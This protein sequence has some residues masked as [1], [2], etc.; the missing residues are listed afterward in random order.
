MKI[1]DY[2][3]F[4]PVIKKTAITLSFVTILRCSV[5]PIELEESF[6]QNSTNP[7]NFTCTDSN[8]E[9]RLINNGTISYRLRIFSPD[10]TNIIQIINIDPGTTTN[11]I[12]FPA[13]DIL[14]AIDNNSAGVTDIKTEV[15]MQNCEIFELVILQDNT[16][17]PSTPTSI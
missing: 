3:N 11:W 6:M 12:S 15:T 2:E 4:Y 14:F 16:M 8:P 1:L 13:G 7:S 9:A 17:L 10:L 5:Q